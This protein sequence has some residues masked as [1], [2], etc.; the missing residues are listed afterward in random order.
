MFS[1]GI[2]L[3]SIFAMVRFLKLEQ[4][5]GEGIFADPVL[6]TTATRDPDFILKLRFWIA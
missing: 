4:E 6:P 2:W 1:I 5:F 3:I